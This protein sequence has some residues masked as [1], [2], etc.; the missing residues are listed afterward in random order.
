MSFVDQD[1]VIALAEEEVMAACWRLIGVEMSLPL[2]RMAAPANLGNAAA[3][4]AA[5]RALDLAIDDGAWA[6]GVASARVP[7]R[8]QRFE[9]EGVEVMVD[10]GHNPQAARALAQWLG[11][12]PQARTVAVYGALADK[13]AAGVVAAIAPGID[14]WC[15]AGTTAAGARGRGA[16]ALADALAGTPAAA[17]TRHA[18]VAAALAAALA[19]AGKGGRVLAFGSFHVAGEALAWLAAAGSEEG[20]GGTV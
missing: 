8:L 9:C 6:R 1:D 10:V 5:L 20:V 18:D 13:D 12:A 17:G 11:E 16:D 19:E 2:P 14:A 7:G 4:I 15:L 3:A